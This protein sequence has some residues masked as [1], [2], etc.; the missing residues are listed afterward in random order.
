MGLFQVRESLWV[1]VVLKLVFEVEIRSLRSL[2]GLQLS[3]AKQ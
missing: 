1:L 2:G 3:C